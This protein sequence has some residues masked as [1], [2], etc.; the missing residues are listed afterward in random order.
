MR[1][2][3]GI[4][5]L[6]FFNLLAVL[7]VGLYA[8]ECT[9]EFPR[10]IGDGTGYY[11]IPVSG[12]VDQSY[13]T[14]SGYADVVGGGAADDKY[15]EVSFTRPDHYIISVDYQVSGQSYSKCWEITIGE[16]L[17]GG[18]ITGPATAAVNDVLEY[19][20]FTS[21][22]PASLGIGVPAGRKYEYQWQESFDG[23]NWTD[24]PAATGLN[25]VGS[26]YFPRKIYFRRMVRDG[27][28]NAYSNVISTDPVVA[29]NTGV[30]KTSQQ[31]TA[32][33]AP[34][35]FTGTAPAG[36]IGTY[37]YQW[38]TSADE[39]TWSTIAGATA[40]GY[41]PATVSATTYFRRKCESGAQW[42]YSNTVQLLVKSGATP[43]T[44]AQK[45]ITTSAVK[46]PIRDY[47]NFTTGNFSR[48]TH[49]TIF[50]PGIKDLTTAD[51]LN[52]KADVQRVVRYADGLGRVVQNIAVAASSSGKDLVAVNSY[53]QYGQAP[54]NHL[55][56]Y[57]ESSTNNGAF[58]PDAAVKQ[59][60]FYKTL[61]G[62][63]FPYSRMIAEESPDPRYMTTQLPG[64]AFAGNNI[65]RRSEARIN[66]EADNVRVWTIGNE[67]NA[68]PVST[69]TYTAA[70]LTVK[71][72]TDEHQLKTLTYTDKQGKVILVAEQEGTDSESEQL[73]TYY[74]YDELGQLRYILPPL[75]V[76]YCRD[77]NL[78][79]FSG[80]EAAGVLSE[81][82]F[83]YLYDELGRNSSFTLPGNKYPNLSVY[84]SRDRVIFFQNASQ[85]ANNQGEWTLNFYDSR[86]RKVMTALYK[87]AA[88]TRESL[89]ALVN[90][91][92]LN[93]QTIVYKNAAPAV[94]YVDRYEA[95][96]VYEAK[97]EI[98]FTGDF[99]THAGGT[100]DAFINPAAADRVENI[101]INS[102]VPNVTN[103]EPL[104]V[105]YYDTYGWPGSKSFSND[106][107][108]SAGSNPYPESVTRSS[109]VTN[110]ITGMK[111]K[112]LGSNNWLS[113]TV[114]YDQ[115]GRI[116]QTL[117][118]NVSGGTEITTSQYDFSGKKLSYYQV[119]TNPL[120]RTDPVIR[121]QLRT[122][123]DVFG[124]PLN[125]YHTLYVNGN[126]VT[127]QIIAN[128]YDDQGR[129]QTSKRGNLE[130]LTYAYSLGGRIK[131]INGDYARDKNANN[132]FGIDLSFE[133]G[134]NKGDMT[135]LLSGVVWRRKGNP[136]EAHAYGY[137][138]DNAGRLSKADYSQNTSGSWNTTLADYTL[139][140]PQYDA[141]GN[142]KKMK[143]EGVLTGSI[144]STI[145]D[146][147]YFNA[148][149][150]WSNRLNGVT[151]AQGDK[152][153]G[154]FK[155]YTGRTTTLDYDY[156]DAGRLTKDRNR[157]ITVINNYLLNKPAK[158][159][160]DVAPVR[161]VE[162]V[163]DAA[164]TM[165]KK[166]VTEG[167]AI[168]T[169]TYISG[170]VYK[171]N[172]LMY[173]PH[174][175]GRVRKNTNGVLVYD[176]FLS[177]H[178]GNVRTVLTEEVNELLYR[179][180]HEDNPQPVP[181]LP[182]REM[183]SF[184]ANI[185]LIPTGHKFYDYQGT[186]NRKFVKL[187]GA[188]TD[189]KI[190][191]GKAL[192]VMAGDKVDV[193][194]FYYYKQNS[195]ANNTTDQLPSEI[196]NQIINTLLGP[197]TVIANGHGN[198]VTSNTSGVILN[199]D[200]F[201]N[202]V[203]NTQQQNPASTVPKAYLNYAFFDDNFNFVDGGFKRVEQ[204]D[205]ILP[206]VGQ[207]SISKNGYLYV[208]LSN[209]SP[210]DVYFDNLA[211]KHTT[212]PLLQEDSYYP[213]GLQIS[214]LSSKALN[215]M[216][217]KYLF[218]GIE[219]LDEFELG[220]Y[221]SFYRTLDPQIGRWWQPDP[222]T[223]KYSSLSP[224]NLS[225]NNPVNFSDPLGNDWFTNGSGAFIWLWN[226]DK[227]AVVAGEI[228]R[229][230]GRN[231]IHRFGDHIYTFIE[232]KLMS[233]DNVPLSNLGSEFVTF[234]SSLNQEYLQSVRDGILGEKMVREQ[235]GREMLG[236]GSLVPEDQ[237]DAF[238]R[239]A[240]IETIFKIKT[241]WTAAMS[242]TD[243]ERLTYDFN[244]FAQANF[245]SQRAYAV[246]SV[247]EG[248][249]LAKSTLVN[250]SASWLVSRG[251]MRL[252]SGA[253]TEIKAA[254]RPKITYVD[255]T[256]VNVS[257][258]ENAGFAQ[259]TF[260][261]NYSLEG[262]LS[263]RTVPEVAQDI[264]TGKMDPSQLTIEYI[265]RDGEV[266][267]LNTRS[268][269]ALMMSDVPRSQ[270]NAINMTGVLEAE[271]RL[272][273][274]LLKNKSPVGGFKSIR[275]SNTQITLPAA[276]YNA[277]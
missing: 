53:D 212:G 2:I 145:D 12:N 213:F 75:A 188:S 154:D 17:L 33:A 171:N 52:N 183:F 108:L 250:V 190:G 42:G 193:S 246:T 38:E 203:Q 274:Q 181:V 126:P 48:I 118:D 136:D 253:S 81:L 57:T 162:F 110:K 235:M 260:N 257:P 27:V 268:S 73:R 159:T 205:Q 104:A 11:T 210:S 264:L 91:A 114:Y 87:D 158:I 89:Q 144:K 237:Q 259:K 58:R 80:T 191:T 157:G 131:S 6:L 251:L 18:S 261:P 67:D 225:N 194:A 101:T 227:T 93:S 37:T 138:Y 151:D 46:V 220:L 149:N 198:L 3:I 178:L 95:P 206:L 85:R 270:W 88:A 254:V 96:G 90:Q 117:S 24:I 10:F 217:N 124:N 177:D 94:L 271:E 78:W 40:A 153:T 215:R 31:L 65:G 120:S 39:M 41:Q 84:D 173:M 170:A 55:A 221:T 4:I 241:G 275:M 23:V 97:Q 233:I 200:D 121:K 74:V 166:I 209:E 60:E 180:T 204:P 56:Y 68:V 255:G 30:I 146:L 32:G 196:V 134:F 102:Y 28:E 133:N 276:G 83:K 176:Y 106:F 272:T 160:L 69:A 273:V 161:S 252:Y 175:V 243:P 127:K 63:E 119:L 116:I 61:T 72:S 184:P 115:K 234:F 211:I 256:S 9:T 231:L 186:V 164:G 77:K 82:G 179:A 277:P 197:V 247:E 202:F 47:S 242:G 199:K 214:N 15:I 218:N 50:R 207:I 249:M 113:S 208:Y 142:I 239:Q 174:P 36:G 103:Y 143:Q 107:I 172:E 148:N 123:Y 7:P 150:E 165:L 132:Y 8:Q 64:K 62:E 109:Y 226:S 70:Q 71:V 129:L 66:T 262:K 147:A 100:M 29:L 86:N 265:I 192:R 43:N 229:N 223:E 267:I 167:T 105:Y 230:V 14:V 168:T 79:N 92:S 54:V 152:K 128:T 21:L 269:A 195:P 141:N 137:M 5:L 219:K 112:V 263:G 34:A 35:A 228:Y 224:Y 44:P 240:D 236:L 139:S 222:E 13:W 99:D 245:M 20:S 51:A 266:Y 59:P 26:A 156:D 125:S 130:T 1:K 135:G 187:N 111:M 98:V 19:S 232:E 49:A 169:Y 248:R 182:E 244:P 216:Q 238:R 201:S 185:D 122:D 140:V 258:I 22:Q 163:Y 45:T 155:N 25:C 189:R 76:K 16:H